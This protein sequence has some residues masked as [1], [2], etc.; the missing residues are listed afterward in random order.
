MNINLLNVSLNP[1]NEYNFFIGLVVNLTAERPHFVQ[2]LYGK[3]SA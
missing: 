1:I 3:F 2:G